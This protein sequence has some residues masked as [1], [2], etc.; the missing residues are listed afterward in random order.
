MTLSIIAVTLRQQRIPEHL[1]GRVSAAFGVLNVASAP[2]LHQYLG[3]SVPTSDFPRPSPSPEPASAPQHHSSQRGSNARP[4][5]RL[6]RGRHRSETNG[7]SGPE[8]DMTS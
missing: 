2:S 4:S 3:S 7:D 8:D 1:L 6:T 5:Q